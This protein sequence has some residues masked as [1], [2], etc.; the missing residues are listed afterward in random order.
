[1]RADLI[2]FA[3]AIAAAFAFTRLF[4]NDDSGFERLPTDLEPY[5]Y[6]PV[7]SVMEIPEVEIAPQGGEYLRAFLYAIQ[8]A[9]HK[10]SDVETGRAYGIAF[11]GFE[12]TDFSDHPTITGEWLGRPLDAA[13]CRAAGL[14]AG[15]KSTAAGAYQIIRPTWDEVRAAGRWG[16]ALPDFSPASQDE[17]ARRVLM[18]C[19]ALEPLDAGN[20]D[21]ATARAAKR[22]ASLPGATSGQPTRSANDFFAFFNQALTRG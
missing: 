7:L 20:L 22:W 3:A 19:G 18:L 10:A 15:C 8:R 1:M 5:Q 6:D 14:R 21:L 9:E 16:A 4:S 17:A 2:G 12:F 13:M 11:G